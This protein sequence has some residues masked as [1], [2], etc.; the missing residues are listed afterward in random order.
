MNYNDEHKY[1]DIINMPHHVSK[2][3]PQMPPLDRAAQFAPFAALTGH[4]SAVKEEARLTDQKILL[5]IEQI[6]EINYI[7]GLIQ[8]VYPTPIEAKIT[9]F[10]EDP[11]KEG[12]AY[13]SKVCEIKRID[14]YERRVIFTDRTYIRIEDILDITC[15]LVSNVE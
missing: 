12:G 11:T 7:L 1:D 9:Y 6:Q 13:L 14:E 3:H 4:D 5:S 8:E 10:Q 2:K 15:S